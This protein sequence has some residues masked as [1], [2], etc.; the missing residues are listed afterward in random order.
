MDLPMTI[1]NADGWAE[2]RRPGS[3]W[4]CLAGKIIHENSEGGCAENVVGLCLCDA[5]GRRSP[6][7]FDLVCCLVV[8]IG[9]ALLDQ[10]DGQLIQLLKVVR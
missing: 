7:G 10:L 1:V 9:M 3:D 5:C 4:C 2:A 6:A 8:H